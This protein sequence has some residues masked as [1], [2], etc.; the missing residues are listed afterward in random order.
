MQH[1]FLHHLVE[2]LLFIGD[3]A[4]TVGVVG[5]RVDIGQRGGDTDTNNTTLKHDSLR[6]G[7]LQERLCA[8]VV[9]LDAGLWEVLPVNA[10]IDECLEF[11]VSTVTLRGGTQ[12]LFPEESLCPDKAHFLPLMVWVPVVSNSTLYPTRMKSLEVST[13]KA[14]WL[15]A[16]CA[17]G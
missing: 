8:K 16:F 6:Q 4:S 3:P 17:I 10:A 9:V 11:V 13:S 5:H 12:G 15:D 14:K 1:S 7:I 2:V